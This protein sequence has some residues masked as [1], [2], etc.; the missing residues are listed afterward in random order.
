MNLRSVTRGPV[1][2]LCSVCFGSRL[3]KNAVRFFAV[4]RRARFE[5]PDSVAVVQM[6]AY[7]TVVAG[8]VEK[9]LARY[10][11]CAVFTQPRPKA[12]I[13]PGLRK[14]PFAGLIPAQSFSDSQRF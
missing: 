8:L 13:P 9:I 6:R 10:E 1:L 14:R 4:G 5:S 11:K 3:C 2:Y 12:V 7:S